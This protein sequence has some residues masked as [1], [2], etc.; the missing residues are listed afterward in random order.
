MRVFPLVCLLILHFLWHKFDADSPNT[1]HRFRQLA[2]G[3]CKRPNPGRPFNGH[4]YFLLSFPLA[5]LMGDI[6]QQTIFSFAPTKR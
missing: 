1:P 6:Y 5:S 4:N 2:R 3:V